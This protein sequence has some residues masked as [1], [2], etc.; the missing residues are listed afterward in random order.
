MKLPRHQS[1][2]IL[3]S[4]LFTRI[5][6]SCLFIGIWI[7]AAF[8]HWD[9]DSFLSKRFV[10]QDWYCQFPGC[11]RSRRKREDKSYSAFSPFC[12]PKHAAKFGEFESS[13]TLCF[14]VSSSLQVPATVCIL[15][16][17]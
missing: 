7:V 1:L 8:V 2:S 9:Y 15:S 16:A 12:S 13:A 17:Q 6:V 10:F 14:I 5:V 4:C 3:V 11:E